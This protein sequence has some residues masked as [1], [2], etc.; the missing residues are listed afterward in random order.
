MTIK[1]LCLLQCSLLL[2]V[3]ASV[4]WQAMQVKCM[5]GIEVGM[6]LPMAGVVTIAMFPVSKNVQG[7]TVAEW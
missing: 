7:A 5:L 1:V 6:I 3:R 2:N 4:Q